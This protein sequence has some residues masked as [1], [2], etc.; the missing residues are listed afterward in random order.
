MQPE[1][2]PPPPP[3][4]VLSCAECDEISTAGVGWEAELATD[5]D[6]E[7]DNEIGIYC[8]TCRNKEFG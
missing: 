3:T 1:E 5:A 2:P 4:F 6:L 8:P 7:D